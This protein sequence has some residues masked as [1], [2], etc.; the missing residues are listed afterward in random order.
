MGRDW[1]PS[2]AADAADDQR[3]R[4]WARFNPFADT[5]FCP[6]DSGVECPFCGRDL[7]EGDDGAF[8]C[9]PCGEFAQ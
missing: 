1:T 5:G 2:D 8:Y 9:K 3:G 6:T 7:P 4:N